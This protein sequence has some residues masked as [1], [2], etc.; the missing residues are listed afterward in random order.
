MNSF[1]YIHH[2]KNADITRQTFQP[3]FQLTLLK[4]APFV[5]KSSIIPG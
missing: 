5:T 1:K 3:L 4:N 2:D